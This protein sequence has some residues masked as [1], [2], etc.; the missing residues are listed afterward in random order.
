MAKRIMI[1]GT[2]PAGLAALKVLLETSQAK[3]GHWIIDS[4]EA[5]DKVGGI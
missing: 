2:G 1:I 5:R 4:F 3:F